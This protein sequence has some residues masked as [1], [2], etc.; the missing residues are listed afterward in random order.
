MR[1]IEIPPDYETYRDRLRDAVSDPLISEHPFYQGLTDWVV[2]H[3][4]PIL[5]DQTHPSEYTNFSIAFNW[6]LRRNYQDT[7]LGSPE[8]VGTMYLMH[9]FTHMT[10]AF[11][12]RLDQVTGAEYADIFTDSEYRASNETEILIHYRIPELRETV[13]SDTRIIFDIMK[14]QNIEQPSAGVLA[15][16]RASAIEG[17]TLDHFFAGSEE[18]QAVLKRLK[19]FNGNRSWAETQYG[20]W[21]PYFSDSQTSHPIPHLQTN[22]YETVISGYTS[23]LN[24]ECYETNIIQNVRYGFALCGIDVPDITTFEQAVELTAELENR[25][26]VTQ[27]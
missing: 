24:Q 25:H 13:L 14:E 3:R 1:N 23:S 4:T 10:V 16:L 17:Q 7:T 2:D 22:T 15:R 9:E 19:S 21:R 20:I 27:L 6:L 26:A 8:T 5:Y 11:P 18:D 12:P